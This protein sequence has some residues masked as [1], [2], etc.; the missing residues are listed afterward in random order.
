MGQDASNAPPIKVG[1]YNLEV[2]DQFTYL[3]STISGNLSI[4]S[5]L[6]KRIGKA[7]ATMARLS[8]KTNG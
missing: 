5:K 8:K 4:Y 1:D 7:S 2:V 3:G 6:N